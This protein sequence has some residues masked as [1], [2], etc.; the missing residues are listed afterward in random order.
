MGKGNLKSK[1]DRISRLLGLLRS[2]E[3]W[4]T[5]SLADE[6]EVSHRTL[7]RDL[8]DL[9]DA[10]YPIEA[11]RG[12][13]GGTRLSGRWGIEKLNLTN[14]EAI[15]LLLCL[16]VTEAL[17]P[18]SHGLG[19]KELKQKIANAF[20]ES[21]RKSIIELRKRIFIG[22]T[23]ST[24]V[25]SNFS[26]TSNEI[27]EQMMNSFVDSKRIEIKYSDEKLKITDRIID[28]QYL[29]LNWPVWYVLAWDY[30]R[31]APRVFRI[32]RIKKIEATNSSITRRN[33]SLLM[34]AY[35]Q[36]FQ[37]L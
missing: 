25:A 11:D 4:T 13:G 5:S 1:N 15:S 21:Q 9:K 8:S 23:A 20:P 31:E 26:H 14:K 24:E 29:L 10:G 2:D 19:A 16:S 22:R 28:P 12:R 37:Q 35:E 27:W 30:L 17:T 7:M 3:H 36:F 32:D 33:K 6:L 34:Q 18:K